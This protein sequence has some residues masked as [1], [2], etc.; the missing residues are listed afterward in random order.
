MGYPYI[1][2]N[3]FLMILLS[4]TAVAGDYMVIHLN[5]KGYQAISDNVTHAVIGGLSWFIVCFNCK[6]YTHRT[7]LEIFSCTFFASIIDIDHFVAA[8]SLRLKDATNLYSRPILHCS[9]VPLV[10]IVTLTV[11]AFLT[12]SKCIMVCSLIMLTAFGS[13]HT[14][15]ATRRGYW[16]YPYGSTPPIPYRYYILITI[17]IPFCISHFLNF[18]LQLE[19]YTRREH[20]TV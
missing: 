11:L 18:Y 17:A 5:S 3:L 15:D 8:R 12:Q 7:L 13:H 19:M 20:I 10:L 6:R 4:L 9:T 1:A 16:F 14:R 2:E